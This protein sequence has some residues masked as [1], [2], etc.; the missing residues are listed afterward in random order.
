MRCLIHLV[1]SKELNRVETPLH[2]ITN[3]ATIWPSNWKGNINTGAVMAADDLAIAAKNPLNFQCVLNT[4]TL[5]AARECYKFNIQKSKIIV[6]NSSPPP[7]L[8]CNGKPMDT[9]DKEPHLVI[10]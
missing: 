2:T 4:A 3:M 7:Q 5:D 9:S 6:I 1:R 8:L 10:I